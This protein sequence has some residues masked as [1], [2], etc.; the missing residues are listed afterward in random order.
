MPI[1]RLSPRNQA[2]K[3]LDDLL[4]RKI[5]AL[6]I[7]LDFVGLECIREARINRKY[8]DQTGNLRSS[9]GYC[10]LY[11]GKV[12]KRSSLE[13]VK[14]TATKGAKEG[15]DFMSK[16]ISENS[17][18]IVLIV[19]AGMNY[20]RY[21]EKMGLNVLDSSEMLAKKLVPRMLKDLGFKR[22]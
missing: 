7:R 4:R 12:V 22:R 14:P 18:G 16:L 1:K 15:N 21:V 6:I 19:V 13:V 11:N 3:F 17:K 2:K 9:T 10:V 20:A 5:Q 8:T